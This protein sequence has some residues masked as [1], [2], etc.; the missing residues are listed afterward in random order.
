MILHTHYHFQRACTFHF[1]YV[2][3]TILN[4]GFYKKRKSN[5]ILCEQIKQ[6]RRYR[7]Q[8]VQE[9]TAITKNMYVTS[10]CY[11]LIYLMDDQ[12]TG[13]INQTSNFTGNLVVCVFVW[14]YAAFNIYKC[15]LI[16]T[17]SPLYITIPAFT[18]YKS[19]KCASDELLPHT[20]NLWHCNI[21]S[22]CNKTVIYHLDVKYVV[23]VNDKN[24]YWP[25]VSPRSLMIFCPYHS[26]FHS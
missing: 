25:R 7:Y 14:F 16:T 11:F 17:V 2:T 12:L 20:N 18:L 9:E 23:G 8:E 15:I 10:S 22:S 3:N 6:F 21:Y 26:I 1:S 19:L 24:P 13:S 5:S 4:N